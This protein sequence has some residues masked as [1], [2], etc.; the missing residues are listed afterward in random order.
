WTYTP[1]ADYNGTDSFVITVKDALGNLTPQTINVT[2]TAVAD[3]ADDT[4]T[5]TSGQATTIDVLVNDTFEGTPVVAAV[6]TAAHG[7]VVNNN[8]GT[9]TYTA[10]AGYVGTDTFT[11]TVTSGGVTE[12]ATVTVTVGAN[13]TTITGVTSGTV[14]EDGGNITGQITATDADG[15]DGTTPYAVTTNGAHGTASVDT[16]G[17][18]T[19][20]PN[21]DYNGTDSFVITVKDALGNLTPQTINVTVTAVA[22]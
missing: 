7:T 5:T 12:T 15:L 9:V 21:A 13:G 19:Y 2:V 10:N 18:W 8:D 16:S 1:N 4:G 6:G 3:I 20:T 22:D 11:Y 17:N 14:A